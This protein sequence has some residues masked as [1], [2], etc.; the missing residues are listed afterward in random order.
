[1]SCS[2][3]LSQIY[4]TND[5]QKTGNDSVDITKGLV[6][7]KAT[8]I[9]TNQIAAFD[10]DTFEYDLSSIIFESADDSVQLRCFTEDVWAHIEWSALQT[11]ET[12]QV[13]NAASASYT[14]LA[15][16]KTVGIV[17]QA[18]TQFATVQLPYGKTTLTA[19]IVADDP[20]FDTEYSVVIVKPNV[21]DASTGTGTIAQIRD[22]SFTPLA[23][24]DEELPDGAVA[25]PDVYQDI[26]FDRQTNDYTSSST[27]YWV[28]EDVG[29]IVINLDMPSGV[30]VTNITYAT[31]TPEDAEIYSSFENG[32]IKTLTSQKKYQIESAGGEHPLKIT[33][34][35]SA[36]DRTYT[37]TIK[38]PASSDT[39]LRKFGYKITEESIPG[40]KTNAGLLAKSGSPIGTETTEATVQQHQQKIM[41]KY[42]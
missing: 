26:S 29:D 30:T 39:S 31:D 9:T 7:L 20:H 36:G 8:D 22:L 25:D 33:T 15:Q 14:G 35:D 37:V 18:D 17:P 21:Y 40:T 10:K 16:P 32:K 41:D 3:I 1:M 19:K 28:N 6:V 38:K 5:I 24:S 34:H 12:T 13:E 11:H 23:L 2:N 4:N 42:S 27:L